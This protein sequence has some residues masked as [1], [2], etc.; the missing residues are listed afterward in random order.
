MTRWSLAD[1]PWQSFDA[2]KVSPQ[3]VSLI[4][5]ACMVE[6][7]SEDY[8]RYLCE[9]FHDDPEFQSAAHQWAGEE[10]QHG[11]SLRK[12]AELADPEF[13]FDTSFD[14]FTTGYELP[15]HVHES[16][17][18]S[19]CGELVSRCVVESG[20]SNYYTAIKEL[21]DEPVLKF[22]CGKIAADEFRHYKMFYEY[23]ETYLRKER[24]SLFNRLQV[25]FGRLVESGDDELAY[26]FFASHCTG[27]R[28]EGLGN[29]SRRRCKKAYL[30]YAS[31]VYRPAHIERMAAMIFKAVGLR[32]NGWLHGLASRLAWRIMRSQAARPPAPP[33]G[34]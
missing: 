32:P 21:T 29:Y 18:G 7:N 30:G 1:V 28:F 3:F 24:I 20:T 31:G 14:I 16:V 11:E 26:A 25:A 33:R 9:V 6:H 19:R 12:W 13:D 15:K 27:R 22:L 8:V 5:A 2:G 4:K 23:L 17:R 10:L 34:G